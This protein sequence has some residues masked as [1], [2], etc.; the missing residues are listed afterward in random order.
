MGLWQRLTVRAFL[1]WLVAASVAM[2]I[3]GRADRVRGSWF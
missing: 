3:G 1:A 2:L